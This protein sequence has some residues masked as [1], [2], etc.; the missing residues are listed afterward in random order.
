MKHEYLV[1]VTI[2][3]VIAGTALASEP[4]GKQGETLFAAVKA[5]D[6]E[7]VKACI[8]DGADVNAK[9]ATGRMPIH[10]ALAGRHAEITAFLI[11]QGKWTGTY[12]EKELRKVR[13][14]LSEGM[15]ID[16]RGLV[17]DNTLLH[18]AAQT[19]YVHVAALL[20]GC[21]ANINAR[22]DSGQT[23]LQVARQQRNESVA[24]LL[25]DATSGA[26]LLHQADLTRWLHDQDA[27]Y[28]RQWKGIHDISITGVTA[29]AQCVQGE[30]VSL[31]VTAQSNGTHR[32]E[33]EVSLRE[34]EDN[35]RLVSGAHA[36]RPSN[37]KSGRDRADLVFD[38]ET[39]TRTCF[40]NRVSIGG[41]VNGDGYPDV[42]VGAYRWQNDRGRAHLYYGGPDMDAVA[43]VVFTGDDIGDG[44]SNQSGSF[45]D[46]NHDGYDDVIIG[47]GGIVGQIRDGYV[48]IYYG[49]PDMD[50]VADIVLRPKEAG[51]RGYF[52]TVTTGDVDNDGYCD[53][54]VGELIRQRA[55]LFW[56]GDPMSIK[57]EVTFHGKNAGK[58]FA[59]GQ[60]MAI[61]GDVN[62]DG[63][64]D[65]LIGAREGGEE[66]QGQA[67]LYFGNTKEKM[68]ADC[69]WLFTGENP[70]DHLGSA[71]DIF[72]I[73]NDGLAEV[74]VSARYGGTDVRGCIYI[75][76]GSTAFDGSKAD[77]VL[78][79]ERNGGLG[80]WIECGHLNDDRIGD[81]LVGTFRYPDWMF[82]HGRA[83]AFYGNSRTLMDAEWDH[84]FDGEGGT[85]DF[86]G[87]QIGVGDVN[88][89]GYADIL[90]GA[91]GV[92]HAIGRA[93]LYYGPFETT[94]D[95]P[96]TWDTANAS[97]GKHTLKVEIPPVPGEQNTEDNAKT[98]TIEV[99]EPGG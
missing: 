22:N 55:H 13:W 92:N 85:L 49:G 66:Q 16:A 29:P 3:L 14:L 72:D 68:D 21:G 7:R 2:A 77:V 78:E 56:G 48:H 17:G 20:V 71:L 47:A 53:V 10:Y 31:T 90:L 42:L 43:D 74:I 25:K 34:D 11:M 83:Y 39:V 15:D 19:G 75:Y 58:L 37:E 57:T 94:T 81:L 41:D 24:L 87:F 76:K 61:G 23:P 50:N 62:G 84:V 80:D 12:E 59:F 35:V 65:I 88:K 95:I 69:D 33:F 63:Y 99:K 8:A 27:D 93:Y 54:L 96:L 38:P 64:R 46:V 36:L 30:V 45:G 51:H 4:R 70:G 82:A 52:A 60:R 89:D 18:L 5:G 44:F 97:I 26:F 86:F 79:G 9:D 67:Y 40:G 6:I 73:D 98:V 32:E 1:C 28:S 91:Q